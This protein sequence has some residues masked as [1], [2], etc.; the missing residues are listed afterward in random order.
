MLFLF[1]LL[2]DV[3][4]KFEEVKLFSASFVETVDATV[5]H[6]KFW[7]G[8]DSFR[9]D[10][11]EPDTQWLFGKDTIYILFPDGE[12][13]ILPDFPPLSHIFYHFRKY[14]KVEEENNKLILIPDDTTYKV[15]IYFSDDL[16][17][18]KLI[19]KS[20]ERYVFHLYDVMVNPR[21]IN[22]RVRRKQ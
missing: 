3:L 7:I 17:P 11:Y 20:D 5:F 19:V 12:S 15:E 6:G 1:F 9:V 16:L 22:F 18:K 14:Y 8:R 21:R 4:R 10:V 2:E 13:Q